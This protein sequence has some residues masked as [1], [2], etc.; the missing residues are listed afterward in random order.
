MADVYRFKPGDKVRV[1]NESGEVVA[2]D[3]ERQ[4]YK[5]KIEAGER[6]ITIAARFVKSLT[7][8]G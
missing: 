1:G 8:E 4:S 2:I 6:E 5:V 3:R 7:E